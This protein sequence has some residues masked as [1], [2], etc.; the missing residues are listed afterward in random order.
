MKYILCTTSILQLLT[1]ASSSLA[2]ARRG[3]V[4][5]DVDTI[6]CEACGANLRFVS[7]ATWTPDEGEFLF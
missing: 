4:N 7:S 1:Q 3:W 6:E 2:C 5:V